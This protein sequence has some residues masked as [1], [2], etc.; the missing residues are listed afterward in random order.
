[1]SSSLSSDPN[2]IEVGL[3]EKVGTVF[4]ALSMM[5]SSFVI[6]L[7]RNWKLALATFCI[8]PYTIFVTGVLTSMDAKIETNVR[9]LYSKA[10]TLAEEALSS[11]ATIVS[12]GAVE[13]IVNKYRTFVKSATTVSLWRGPLQACTYGNLWFA[14]HAV[15]A[16]AL[17]YGTHL[18]A[19]GDIKNGG[20]VLTYS[21]VPS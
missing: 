4:Q 18:V 16:L 20:T 8:I 14:I 3:G 13:K 12:L 1:V 7:T 19:W 10:S 15:Y 21:L 5:I 9:H 6:A 11:P 17:F 2:F